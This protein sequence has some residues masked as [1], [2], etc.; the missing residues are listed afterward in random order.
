MS[1]LPNKTRTLID[2]EVDQKVLDGIYSQEDARNIL[3]RNSENNLS[4]E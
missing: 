1:Q 3:Y 4:K 2:V